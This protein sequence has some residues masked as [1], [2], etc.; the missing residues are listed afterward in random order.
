MTMPQRI[1]ITDD[2]H[3]GRGIQRALQELAGH[4]ERDNDIQ[5]CILYIPTKRNIQGTT[6]T[7]ILGEKISKL[8][9]K[10]ETIEFGSASIK[11]ETLRSLKSYSKADAILVVYANNKMMDV[12]DSNKYVKLIIAVPY[13]N[14]DIEE[15]K[16][17]WNPSTPNG[18]SDEEK[19]I[20]DS[21]VEAALIGVTKIINL[22]NNCL[23]PRDEEAIKDAFRI[24]HAHNHKEVPKNI[25]AWCIRHAWPAQAADDAMKQASKA[26]SL[27]TK[28]KIKRTIFADDIYEKWKKYQ[29]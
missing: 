11:L 22:G 16:R 19:L 8:L 1:L 23:N 9:S 27:R 29:P 6:L 10:N 14:A 24:L 25:R 15:W 12:V 18:E 2:S 17:T 20:Q 5:E 4:I 21:M 28:P 7:G 3:D 26:F 13:I